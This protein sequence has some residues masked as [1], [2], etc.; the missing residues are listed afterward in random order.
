[1]VDPCPLMTVQY[2]VAAL[3]ARFGCERV[4]C[5][6]HGITIK[7]QQQAPKG[8]T[9]VVLT[10]EQAKYLVAHPLGAEDLINQT[11]PA[12]W[13][14]SAEGMKRLPPGRPVHAETA[15]VAFSPHTDL[16]M[17]SAQRAE[18]ADWPANPTSSTRSEK[19]R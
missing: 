18:V 8:F 6:S 2:A 4:T 14:H 9:L 12:D 1:M 13:P 3:K 11:Y 19:L 15:P 7:L 5:D 17:R 10:A 16:T